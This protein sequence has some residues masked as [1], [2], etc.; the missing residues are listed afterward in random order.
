MTKRK[1]LAFFIYFVGLV[2]PVLAMLNCSGWDEG[3]MQ[4]QSCVI[5]S[6]FIRAYANFYYAL[7]LFS[8]FMVLIPLIIYVGVIILIAM[9][10][11]KI[12]K[13]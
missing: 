13:E 12:I 4:V 11:P 9:F 8:A 10:L 1:V 2:L 5:D 3:S 6:D 7:L